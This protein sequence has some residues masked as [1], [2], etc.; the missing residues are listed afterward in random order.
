MKTT[1]KRVAIFSKKSEI[2]Y[3]SKMSCPAFNSFSSETHSI[4]SGNS[5]NIEWKSE[6]HSKKSEFQSK[7]SEFPRSGVLFTPKR[8]ECRTTH[9][10]VVV[11]ST[12]RRVNCHSFSS[13]FS[14]FFK[15]FHSF[16]SGFPLFLEWI[17]IH[18]KKS[19]SIHSFTF[20][21]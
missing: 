19:Y 20:R 15:W 4:K 16:L 14:L 9:F 21:E 7:K 8:V 6:F 5:L 2:Y 3:H 17:T 10:R 13:G 1:R 18:S 11:N 12:R